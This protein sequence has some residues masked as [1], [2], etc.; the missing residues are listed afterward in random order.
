MTDEADLPEDN[1]IIDLESDAPPS[2]PDSFAPA[3][4]IAAHLFVRRIEDSVDVPVTMSECQQ[5][6]STLIEGIKELKPDLQATVSGARQRPYGLSDDSWL[7]VLNQVRVRI[8]RERQERENRPQLARQ[9]LEPFLTP[10]LKEKL[11]NRLPAV[12]TESDASGKP[13]VVGNAVC[14]K[15]MVRFT[16]SEGFAVF[17]EKGAEQAEKH[18]FANAYQELADKLQQLGAKFEILGSYIHCVKMRTAITDLSVPTIVAVY[19]VVRCKD[20]QEVKAAFNFVDLADGVDP[21]IHKPMG[22]ARFLGDFLKS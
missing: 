4:E 7:Y 21:S 10:E 8:E 5:R 13:G 22:S 17:Q 2:E 15:T 14:L 1:D 16:M 9:E 11:R 12:V 20:P 19:P 6:L 3:R 18:F